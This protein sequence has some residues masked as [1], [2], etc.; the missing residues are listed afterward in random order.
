M[1]NGLL[2]STYKYFGQVS[3]NICICIINYF[4]SHGCVGQRMRVAHGIAHTDISK[5]TDCINTVTWHSY[6][7]WFIMHGITFSSGLDTVPKPRTLV[8]F[9]IKINHNNFGFKCSKK[10]SWNPI[11][12]M[13]LETWDWLESQW[14]AFIPNEAKL[15]DSILKS[16]YKKWYEIHGHRL[17]QVE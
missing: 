4:I 12:K 17:N 7:F 8:F 15:V 10:Q 3:T 13:P 14:V 6:L 16:P 5:E 2:A 11:V 1:W 9:L